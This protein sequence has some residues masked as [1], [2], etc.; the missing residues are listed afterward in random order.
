MSK[1][2]L[3]KY[4][5]NMVVIS[6]KKLCRYGF[7]YNEKKGKND[8]DC[9]VNMGSNTWNKSGPFIWCDHDIKHNLKHSIIMASKIA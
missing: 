5:V 1:C 9:G 4:V 6:K 3:C 8:F 2:S 7:K